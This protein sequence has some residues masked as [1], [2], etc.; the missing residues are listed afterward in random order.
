[1]VL[2]RDNVG[3][4]KV[5]YYRSTADDEF[6]AYDQLGPAVRQALREGP[7]KSSSLAILDQIKAKNDQIEAENAVRIL[8]GRPL[9]RLLDPQDP[10]LDVYLARSF[11]G[12]NMQ[13]LMKDRSEADA[14]L[15]VTPIRPVIST[16][17]IREQR[18][19]LRA[20]RWR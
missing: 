12:L 6:E 8:D 17:S 14:M 15:G 16:K 3:D 10:A 4:Q 5:L 7:I 1:M 2:K 19:S 13:T 18:R 20:S 11:L 9:M